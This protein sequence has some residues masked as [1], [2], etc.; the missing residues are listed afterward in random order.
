LTVIGT[1]TAA[2]LLVTV[3]CSYF[4][5]MSRKSKTLISQD[6]QVICEFLKLAN[7]ADTIS[8]DLRW[9][10]LIWMKEVLGYE[11]NEVAASLCLSSRAVERC[12]RKL[13]NAG[14]INR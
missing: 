3:A 12:R 13:L 5:K 7:N 8:K 10:H 14:D 9:H 4:K 6:C 2:S 1:G 11:V